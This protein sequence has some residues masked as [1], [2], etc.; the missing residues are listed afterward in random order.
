MAKYMFKGKYGPEGVKG[1]L[2]EGG[3]SRLK[4][5]SK[6]FA[7]HGCTLEAAY[8]AFGEDDVIGF[9]DMPDTTTATAMSLAVNA[10]GVVA[11]SITPLI[12]AE[13]IDKAGKIVVDYRPAGS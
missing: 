2:K 6:L 4:Y 7:D 5:I 13:E 9:C 11:L 1:L 12:T 3:S 10:S 8:F